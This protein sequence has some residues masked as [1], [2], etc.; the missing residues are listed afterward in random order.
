[1][2]ADPAHVK[3]FD[4]AMQS[5]QELPDPLRRLDAIRH[6]ISELDDLERATV[7]AARAAG[8]TW[9]QIGALYGLSKQGAQQ[10]FRRP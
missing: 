5:L 2:M 6:C 7:A 9:T 4:R 1:M 10:R 3:R 8:V